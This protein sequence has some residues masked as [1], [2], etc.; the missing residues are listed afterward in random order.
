MVERDFKHL[1]KHVRK[2]SYS[3]QEVFRCL[4]DILSRDDKE[5]SVQFKDKDYTFHP[6]TTP[7]E[8]NR[9][10]RIRKEFIHKLLKHCS[11][12][13][14]SELK[15]SLSDTLMPDQIDSAW[16]MVLAFAM[17]EDPRDH[18]LAKID[19]K[20]IYNVESLEDKKSIAL[21]VDRYHV[22]IQN[23]KRSLDEHVE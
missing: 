7:V 23:P 3:L 15:T 4:D 10:Q 17:G 12:D 11:R 14:I 20:S 9:L 2:A 6:A 1:Q 19:L 16:E 5:F 22:K 21:D 8:R 13:L 18:Q